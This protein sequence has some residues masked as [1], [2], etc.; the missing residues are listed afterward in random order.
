MDIN[1]QVNEDNFIT[2]INEIEES[3]RTL[4][5]NINSQE[6]LE[7]LLNRLKFSEIK[8]KRDIM[9]VISAKLLEFKSV[10]EEIN[11]SNQKALEEMQKYNE[12]LKKLSIISTSKE[13]MTRVRILIISPFDMMMEV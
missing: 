6:Y 4:E 10:E 3:I 9:K 8:N 13:K 2:N 5:N 12:D 1:I 7:S 11:L